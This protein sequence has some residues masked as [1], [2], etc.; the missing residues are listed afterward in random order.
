MKEIQ[1]KG[2]IGHIY[3]LSNPALDGIIKIGHTKKSHPELRATELSSSTSIPLP[4]KLECSWLVE[5]PGSREALIHRNLAPCRVS[6]DREFFK[7]TPLEAEKRIN[8]LLYGCEQAYRQ[9]FESIALL[10][11]KYPESFK[12]A[13]DFIKKIESVL[14]NWPA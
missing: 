13:E 10:Y 14:R 12:G 6:K 2:N 8:T 1:S 5:N 4:F 11:R 9:Q 3:I 7:I